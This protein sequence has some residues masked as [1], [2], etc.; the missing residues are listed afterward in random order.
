MSFNVDIFHDSGWIYVIIIIIPILILGVWMLIILLYIIM[1][2]SISTRQY[3]LCVTS[4]SISY[5]NYYHQ[6]F[7]FN[8]N[9][10]VLF[11]SYIFNIIIILKW[12]E[13]SVSAKSIGAFY[14]LCYICTGLCSI[15]SWPHS[16]TKNLVVFA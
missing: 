11:V 9:A 15:L 2:L 10:P 1:L 14:F 5:K 8:M 6:Y 12:V 7:L 3:Y 16:S 4:S 13:F